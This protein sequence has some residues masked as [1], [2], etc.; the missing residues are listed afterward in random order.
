MDR[1]ATK[2]P[3][4]SNKT[5]PKCVDR[6]ERTCAGPNIHRPRS[7]RSLRQVFIPDH[8]NDQY[9][10]YIGVFSIN[11]I[12]DSTPLAFQFERSKPSLS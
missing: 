10:S 9:R 4:L 7:N 3:W 8:N 1:Q 11:F 5:S 12:E 6:P 2:D